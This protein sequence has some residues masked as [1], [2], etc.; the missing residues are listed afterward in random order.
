MSL[1]RRLVGVPGQAY[2]VN[3]ALILCAP[4]TGSTLLT[5]ILDSHS[6]IASPFEI[7]LPAIF[8]GD[9][10]EEKAKAKEREI[11]GY[12]GLGPLKSR[13]APDYFLHGVLSGEGKELLV[14]KDPRYALFV[15]RVFAMFGD[16][17]VIVLTRDIR[18]CSMSV[19][20]GGAYESGMK[21]WH[22]FNQG[23]ESEIHRYS[24][25]MHLKY[26]DLTND[27]EGKTA[28]VTDFLG[29]D[30]EAGM[31]EYWNHSHTDD[32]LRLWNG[33]APKESKLQKMLDKQEISPD[34]QSFPDDVEAVYRAHPEFVEMNQR[35][36][37]KS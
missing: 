17:P 37:Y 22:A 20:F 13:V 4:R 14:L 30:Y 32:K 35:L 15:D 26:E 3:L 25:V 19:M 33:G 23:I 1:V 6:R 31:T 36:G 11:C 8:R 28:V 21:T 5:R 7:G 18:A 2:D 12:Y 10:K 16:I 34:H 9:K 24:R 27:P 29:F